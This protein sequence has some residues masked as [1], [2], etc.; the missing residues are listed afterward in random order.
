MA[1]K[2]KEKKRC[3]T[4]IPLMLGHVTW[5]MAWCRHLVSHR[6]SET[7]DPLS[8]KMLNAQWPWL[9]IFYRLK[10]GVNI[11]P[12]Y[13]LMSKLCCKLRCV[14]IQFL[15]NL[16]TMP[17]LQNKP[18]VHFINDLDLVWELE[19]WKLNRRKREVC[20]CKANVMLQSMQI[21]VQGPEL[22]PIMH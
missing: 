21:S 20:H 11:S 5:S 19:N 1:K 2:R 12:I 14:H 8:Q 4:W 13:S 10:S 6:L 15:H 17:H 9:Q 18:N 3:R 16:I 7:C 22:F